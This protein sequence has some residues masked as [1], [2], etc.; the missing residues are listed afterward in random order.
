MILKIETGRQGPNKCD[1]SAQPVIKTRNNGLDQGQQTHFS[2]AVTAVCGP[3]ILAFEP[4]RVGEDPVTNI[5]RQ[6]SNPESSRCSHPEC[7]R[8]RTCRWA[9]RWR[10]ANR[11]RFPGQL[12]GDLQHQSCRSGRN[13]VSR[14]FVVLRRG[15]AG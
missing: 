1:L 2:R 7:S 5:V 8:S 9:V 10:S 11:D 6:S 15:E 4:G 14:R 12:P 13:W 3:G